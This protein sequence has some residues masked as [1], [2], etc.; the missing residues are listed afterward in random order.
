MARATSESESS[1]LVSIVGVEAGESSGMA[2]TFCFKDFVICRLSNCLTLP[3][4]SSFS[5]GAPA[6]WA[7]GASEWALRGSGKAWKAAFSR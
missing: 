4:A 5:S 7:A 1:K 6:G 2:E 3:F